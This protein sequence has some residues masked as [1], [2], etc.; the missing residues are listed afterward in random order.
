MRLHTSSSFAQ[1]FPEGMAVSLPLAAFGYSK[2]KAFLYGQ[3][4]GMVEPIAAVIGAAVVVVAVPI[5]PYAL[6]SAAGKEGGHGT[7]TRRV[8]GV[9]WTHQ[10]WIQPHFAGVMVYVVFSDIIPEALTHNN[11]R[12]V[13]C[14][15]IAGFIV[16]MI[17][18]TA[19]G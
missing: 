4:S 6:C 2:I 7:R 16:M 15:V 19:L 18:E 14:S 1:N 3:I 17:L 13:A 12:L 8:D 11:Q 10:Q 5:L 9:Y